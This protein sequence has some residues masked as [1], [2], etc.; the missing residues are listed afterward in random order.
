[1]LKE[2]MHSTS[3]RDAVKVVASVSG[4]SR[5]KIYQLAIDLL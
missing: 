2:E 5:R 4:I 3:M 1:M